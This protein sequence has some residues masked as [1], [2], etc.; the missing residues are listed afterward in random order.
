[1]R[2][3]ALAA[4]LI[5]LPFALQASNEA[6]LAAIDDSRIAAV[7][8]ADR[9]ELGEHLSDALH[10]AHSNGKVDTKTSLID[11]L[12]FGRVRYS[13][14]E[15]QE[16]R[17]SFPTPDIALMT[18]RARV[19]AES[20]AGKLDGTLGYLAVWRLESGKWRLLAWQSTQVPPQNL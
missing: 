9:K 2:L 6:T 11:T 13:T 17:F 16:R 7:K 19:Q 3:T 5:F 18:G 14:Y 20:P 15:H 12:A 4:L 8:S 10:Y 1:M